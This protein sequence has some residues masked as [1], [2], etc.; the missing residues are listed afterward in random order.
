MQ[1]NETALH[2][3][4]IHGSL[5]IVRFLVERGA[6]INAHSGVTAVH[7]KPVALSRAFGII[8]KFMIVYYCLLN[9]QQ[10]SFT[11]LYWASLI[12]QAAVVKYLVEQGADQ[13]LLDHVR[14]NSPDTHAVYC[15]MR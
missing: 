3:P 12:G 8:F 6:D 14:A 15:A 1:S 13:T 5:E 4:A 7:G 10:G 2:E 11:A 9:Q